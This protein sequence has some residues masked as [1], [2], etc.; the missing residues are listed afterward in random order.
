[1]PTYRPRMACRL[2]VPALGGDPRATVTLP[3]RV[4]QASL[5]LNDHNHAD[6]LHIVADWRDAGVDPRLIKN[7][8]C[9]FWMGNADDRGTF[10]PNSDNF[11]FVGVMKSPRRVAKEGSGF[12][13]ELEFHDYTT[14]F[15]E[16]KPFPTAGVPSYKDTIAD[17]WKKVCDHTGPQDEDGKVISLV[18]DL[19][20][21]IDF[22]GGARGDLLLG[23]AVAQRFAKLSSV[24]VKE[25]GDSWAVWQQCIGMMGL[26]SFIDRD[27]CVVTTSTEYYTV[28]TA[29]RFIWGHNVLDAQEQTNANFSDKGVAL[30]SFD[31]I[32]GTTIEAFF[33]PPGDK[34]IRR[35]RIGAAK[36][37]KKPVAFPSERYDFFEYHGVTDVTRLFEIAER[38]WDERSRQELDGKIKTVEMYAKGVDGATVDLLDLRC[39]DAVRIEIDPAHKETLIG[40]LG[41]ESTAR[42]YLA[43]RGYSP[44]AST[45]ILANLSTMGTLDVT[46]HTTKVRIALEADGDSGKFEIDIDYHNRIKFDG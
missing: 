23:T 43:T 12:Q 3:I 8:T 45:L 35:K 2:H 20:D 9:E 24:A 4:R 34:R 19:R 26:I 42:E 27:H 18:T 30:T 11:R 10:T 41:S 6:T 25:K 17:A 29:P 5:E 21:A 36:H 32:T 39:G 38:V 7:A 31:P 13:V 40:L 33:P 14:I 15:L 46:F 44:E 22:R 16:Q 1:M 28:D 37:S